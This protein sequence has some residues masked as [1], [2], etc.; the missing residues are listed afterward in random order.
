MPH[1][2]QFQF[3]NGSINSQGARTV[4]P[5]PRQFQFQNGSINRVGLTCKKLFDKVFQFQNGSINRRLV[6]TPA[7]G[8]QGFNSKMVRLIEKKADYCPLSCE[9]QF[10]NGSI[11]RPA[12]IALL[13]ALSSFNSKMV[14]LI[15]RRNTCND[16]RNKVSIPK[17]FD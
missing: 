1:F 13:A 14:R 4:L 2:P 8:G 12:M 11:N 17:W 6:L 15:E 3:Q 10:Q 5:L 9:F 7:S 16:R